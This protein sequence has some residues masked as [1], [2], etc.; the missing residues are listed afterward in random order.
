MVVAVLVTGVMVGVELSVAV[1]VAPIV[2]RL[3]ARAQVAARAELA[4]VLG[5][6]MPWWYGVSVLTVAGT[7]ASLWGSA[8]AWVAAVALVFLLAGVVMSV[9]LLVPVNER[10]A[11]WAEVE[12]SQQWHAQVATW[13]RL[14]RV[15][16]LLIVLA[17]AGVAVA[18]AQG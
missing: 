18:V 1:V 13:D 6:V 15:R 14:H 3:P 16:V 4:R 12:G 17:L 5:R 9:T 10:L 8:A 2:G 7:V 11:Q